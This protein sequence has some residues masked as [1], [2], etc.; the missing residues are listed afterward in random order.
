MD[1]EFFYVVIIKFHKMPQ[2]SPQMSHL[3]RFQRGKW[4][5]HY[6]ILRLGP[7]LSHVKITRLAQVLGF[8]ESYHMQL[9]HVTHN[10][11]LSHKTESCHIQLSHVTYSWV[12]SH[13][14]ESCHIQLSRVTLAR[15]TQ[16]LGFYLSYHIQLSHVTYNW[17]ISHTTESCHMWLSHVPYN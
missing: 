14:I 15:L 7:T 10:W 1:T 12:M 4:I 6:G 9:S 11:V 8:H 17:V 13:T 2:L 5:M 16:V 3:W